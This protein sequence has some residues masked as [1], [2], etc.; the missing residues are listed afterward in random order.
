MLY[1]FKRTPTPQICLVACLPL[2]ALNMNDPEVQEGIDILESVW[3][4]LAVS[5]VEMAIDTYKLNEDQARALRDVYLKQNNY[6]VVL[7]T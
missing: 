3:Y 1:L 5:I 7:Q 6:Y 2:Q 4:V